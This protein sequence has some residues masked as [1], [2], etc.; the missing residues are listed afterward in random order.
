MNQNNMHHN[1]MYNVA[2]SCG[3]IGIRDIIYN[4]CSK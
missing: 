1:Y 3:T 4:L 2:N